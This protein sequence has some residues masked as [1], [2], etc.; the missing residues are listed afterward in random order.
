MIGKTKTEEQLAIEAEHSAIFGSINSAKNELVI[1]ANDKKRVAQEKIDL[2]TGN[3]KLIDD[4]SSLE[5][6]IHILVDTKSQKE[7]EL[8]D[9]EKEYVDKKI[10]LEAGLPDTEKVLA[11]LE[12]K[13][14]PIQGDIS[15]LSQV[16]LE[17]QKSLETVENKI[18]DSKTELIDIEKSIEAKNIREDEL[19]KSIDKKQKEQSEIQLKIDEYNTLVSGNETRKNVLAS[20]NKE[21]IEAESK[22][23]LMKTEGIKELETELA[24]L[25]NSINKNKEINK[26]EESRHFALL[27][28][29]QALDSKESFIK[30]Q[31]ERAGIKWE[32]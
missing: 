13:K 26:T 2:E 20:I 16:Q 3:T 12:S 32:E 19:I 21:I 29:Q 28:K 23:S 17:S 15:H 24:G 30:S 9:L 22:L 14:I 5:D 10:T 11:D 8:K 18:E 1:I 25:K 27:N 31:Y 7:Q 6:A 4:K